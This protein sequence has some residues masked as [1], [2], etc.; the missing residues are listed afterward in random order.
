M[1]TAYLGIGSN[2]DPAPHISAGLS[3]ISLRYSLLAISSV[4]RT[5]AVGFRGAPFLNLVVKVETRLGVR[6]LARDIKQLERDYGRV[7]PCTK[8]SSRRL[9]IDILTYDELLGEHGGQSLPRDEITRN[10][11]VLCPFSELAPSL[12]IPG[13]R[14]TLAAL[15]ERLPK[16][17]FVERVAFTWQGQALPRL[18]ESNLVNP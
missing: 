15:W 5:E 9:D 7:E 10:A 1:H 8:F 14:E 3:E 18:H 6:Q 13:Q 17:Q 12:V 16:D 11:F 4:Y 2:I